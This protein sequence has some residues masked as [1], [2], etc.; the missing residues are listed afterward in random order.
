MNIRQCQKV[1]KKADQSVSPLDFLLGSHFP[2]LG[3]RTSNL[4]TPPDADEKAQ[5]KLVYRVRR[6]SRLG[7]RRRIMTTLSHP[8]TQYTLQPSHTLQAARHSSVQPH[9]GVSGRA[10]QGLQT[11]LP[12]GGDAPAYFPIPASA[13]SMGTVAPPCHGSV[14]TG[15]ALIEIGV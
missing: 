1:E 10:Q 12:P 11:L 7:Q 13:E 6:G 4:R 8:N 15:P 9:P 2:N 5:G 3:Q 14:Q